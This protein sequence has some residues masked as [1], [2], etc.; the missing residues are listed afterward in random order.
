VSPDNERYIKERWAHL[1]PRFRAAH[2]RY[3]QARGMETLPPPKVDLYVPPN[4][5]VEVTAAN[6]ERSPEAV[7][8][9]RQYMGGGIPGLRGSEGFTDKGLIQ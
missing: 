5:A 3:L 7:A 1:S 6:H 4:V 2:N 9:I 8:A